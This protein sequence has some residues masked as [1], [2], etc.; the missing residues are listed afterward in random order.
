MLPSGVFFTNHADENVYLVTRPQ[1]IAFLGF[2]GVLFL[3]PV[4][5]S[6]YLL[7][8]ITLMLIALVAVY[9][10]QITTGMAGQ[11]NL[12]QSAFVGVGAFLTA[13][14]SILG[15]PFWL[16]MP[17]AGIGT[18]LS[19]VLFGL[20]AVRVKGFYLA[21]TTF[22]AQ[23]MFPIIIIRMPTSW[24]GGPNGLPVSSPSLFGYT[25]ATPT[26]MYYFCLVTALIASV[27][28]FNL[29][30][31]RMGRAFQALRD[32]DIAADVLG[33]SPLRYKVLAFFA[34][35]FL[36]GVAG[37]LY[38]YYVRYVTTEQFTLWHSVWYIGM[39]I[40]GGLYSPL[41]AILGTV[42]ISSLQEILHVFGNMLM[43][44]GL[45][46]SGGFIFA[47]TNVMLGTIIILALI[48]EP[49]GLAHRWSVIKASYRIWPYPHN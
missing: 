43:A 38:A 48:F 11:L 19:S 40:V 13:K 14:L 25:L 23:I 9:G 5:V 31:S 16:A 34:G 8:V 37:A 6:P 4:L 22:A 36:A 1:W 44:M 18:G 41:G 33:I 2:L 39:L 35:A 30:R 46:L 3:L 32:N 24:F 42:F 49:Y 45:G 47:A 21:L 15:A 26:A 17:L 10:L 12:G 28:A 20:P 7:G 29:A 27:F